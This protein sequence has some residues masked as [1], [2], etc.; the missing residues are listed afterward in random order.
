MFRLLILLL[1]L[2]LLPM[3]ALAESPVTF[4]DDLTGV[5]TWP[6][7]AS[8]E[9]ASYVYRYAYPQ[10]AGESELAMTINQ[11][12]QY[13]ADDALGFEC[14]MNASA[15]DPAL[16]R[17][18]VVL[19]YTI[20]HLSDEFLS[21]RVDKTVTVGDSVSHI[22][23]GYSFMLTGMEAGTVTSL[24]YLLGVI[25]P[26]DTDEW[27]LDRQTAKADAC[28]RDLVWMHIERDMRAEGSPIYEDMTFEEFEWCFYPEEDFYLDEEGNFVFFLQENMIAPQ[29]DG[30]FFYTVTLD[31]LLDEI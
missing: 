29:E 8:E 14:P 23:K 4:T 9:E 10:I 12:F 22:V 11:V 30:Q 15:H 31:E 21:V 1:A 28:A 7:G 3:A 24:P 20:T 17:M 18:E 25:D 6:E 2:A 26:E 19:L 13:E 5:Y 27:Y 16:G